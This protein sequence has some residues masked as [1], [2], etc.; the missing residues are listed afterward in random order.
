MS[1]IHIAHKR[2][3]DQD[4][5]SLPPTTPNRDGTPTTQTVRHQRGNASRQHAARPR[6]RRNARKHIAK[7]LSNTRKSP[8]LRRPKPRFLQQN[9]VR[10]LLGA[11]LS[12]V[13]PSPGPDTTST[14]EAKY[15]ALLRRLAYGEAP[16]EARPLPRLAGHN[17]PQR[18]SHEAGRDSCR[19]LFAKTKPNRSTLRQLSLLSR[20]ENQVPVK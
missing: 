15:L 20:R 1:G 6:H 3:I 17:A 16:A 7:L 10:S 11:T 12:I 9:D 13:E 14:V 4:K 5:A 18:Y 19:S 2:A 8:I